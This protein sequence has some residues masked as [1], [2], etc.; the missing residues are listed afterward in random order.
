MRAGLGGG[1]ILT[2]IYLCHTCSYQEILRV[3]TPG[4]AAGYRSLAEFEAD[5]LCLLDNARAWEQ[6]GTLCYTDAQK[7]QEVS[8]AAR[9]SPRPAP[10][11]T[12]H[13]Q[14]E[15]PHPHKHARTRSTD[16]AAQLTRQLN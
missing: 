13:T 14:H 3:D 9:L 1:S 8:E 16:K 10:A 2:E 4:Q 5:L 12:A 6:P 11:A 15:H 7:L